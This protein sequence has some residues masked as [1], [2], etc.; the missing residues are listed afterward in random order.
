MRRGRLLPWLLGL[1][2][3]TAGAAPA[4]ETFDYDLVFR[5]ATLYTGGSALAGRGDVATRGDRIVAV[6]RAP[7]TARSEIDAVGLVVALGF[8]DLHN[9]SDVLYQRLGWLPF[10]GSIH[11]NLNYLTQGVTTVVTGNCGSGAAEAEE[12]KGWLD[13]VDGLPFG[14]NVIHLVP[15]GEIRRLAMGDEHADRA[16]PRPTPEERGLSSG[17]EYDPGGR[18]ETDELRDVASFDAS[19]RYSQGVAYLVVNGVL[20]IDAGAYTGERAGRALRRGG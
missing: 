1:A 13:R 10:P 14:T 8:I 11:A 6:G 18:A 3:V 9:H 15:H 17:L 19:G 12:V 7:G 5:G 4:E 20:S 16:D 2:A